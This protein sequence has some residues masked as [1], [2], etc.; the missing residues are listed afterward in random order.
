[1][2]EYPLFMPPDELAEK[3]AKNWNK[4]EA[5]AYFDWFIESIE[6]RVNNFLTIIDYP[7]TSNLEVDLNTISEKVRRLIIEKKFYE[8]IIGTDEKK[9]NNFGYAIA[10]DVGLLISTIL[11]KNHPSLSWIIATGRKSYHSYNLPVL[12]K[13]KG[14]STEIDPLF[15]FIHKLGYNFR[16]ENQPFD[17]YG[18]YSSLSNAVI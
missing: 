7:L 12:V 17:L 11:R 15:L 14:V 13:F 8:S 9:L 18:Q 6:L 3:G 1:M 16:Y 5:R 4:K 10:V 2:S